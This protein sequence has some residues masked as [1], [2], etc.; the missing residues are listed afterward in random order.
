MTQE[1]AISQGAQQELDLF[2]VALPPAK[3][4]EGVEVFAEGSYLPTVQLVQG[5]SPE[6]SAPFHYRPGNY[7]KKSGKDREQIGEKFEG[8]ILDWRARAVHFTKEPSPEGPK[9]VVIESY[10]F[11]SDEFKAIQ[12]IEKAGTKDSQNRPVARWGWEFL[13]YMAERGE[14]VI[15]YANSP[16]TRYTAQQQLFHSLRRP[17]TFTSKQEDI[18]GKRFHSVQVMPSNVPLAIVPDSQLLIAQVVR[19]QKLEAVEA[20]HTD[21]EPVDAA[22]SGSLGNL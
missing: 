14:F 11:E 5:I 1:L 17:L 13:I 3:S 15:F 10:D 21:E 4:L 6:V 18:K 12:E 16:S 20:A 7:L 8:V 22:G 19:F 2:G 9:D